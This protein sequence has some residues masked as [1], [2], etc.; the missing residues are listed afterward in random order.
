MIA[1]VDEYSADGHFL[2]LIKGDL[3]LQRGAAWMPQ[4]WHM[5]AAQVEDARRA[6]VGL[7]EEMREAA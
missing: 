6:S 5:P 7:Y 3:L 4:T 2:Y 1:A